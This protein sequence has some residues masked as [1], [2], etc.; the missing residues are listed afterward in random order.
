MRIELIKTS[1]FYDVL[2]FNIVDLDKNAE[3]GKLE[4]VKV[5]EAYWLNQITIFH[6]LVG[7]GYGK[8]TITK[9]LSEYSPFRI[10]LSDRSGHN[11]NKSIKYTDTRY[12]SMDGIYLAKSCF[13]KAILNREHFLLPFPKKSFSLYG[14]YDFLNNFFS[15]FQHFC[16]LILNK[17]ESK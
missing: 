4:L 3:V 15:N 7:I 8:A 1:Q 17:I 13:E 2:Q 9:I 10:S 5:D 11:N 6:H 12:L 16:H 14:E